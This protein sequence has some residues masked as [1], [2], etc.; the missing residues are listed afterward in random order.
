MT[1]K[2]HSQI[3]NHYVPQFL[4]RHWSNSRGMV[5][6]SL[7]KQAN[8]R[9][10]S[11]PENVCAQR[12]IYTDK[13]EAK[14]S[15]LE[16]LVSQRWEQ[17]FKEFGSTPSR[18]ILALFLAV[19]WRRGPMEIQQCA[20]IRNQLWEFTKDHM[21]PSFFEDDKDFDLFNSQILDS[22]HEV[23]LRFADK[24]WTVLNFRGVPVLETCDHP[25]VMIH[26]D[27]RSFGARTKGTMT[28]FP[29]TP[30]LGLLMT[31]P[32]DRGDRIEFLH[33]KFGERLNQ[34]TRMNAV[35]FLVTPPTK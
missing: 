12:G 8:K 5:E 11:D 32:D 35:Q 23:A 28:F 21:P 3:K 31:D 20:D 2:L 9:A 4:L 17:L 15:E 22:T 25:V 1:R 10:S 19:Q 14:L 34:L 6:F 7:L 29:A 27:K 30:S 16:G 13:V 26:P 24:Q 33:P 18:N